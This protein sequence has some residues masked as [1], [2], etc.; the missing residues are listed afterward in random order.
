[1]NLFHRARRVILQ[2]NQRQP[3]LHTPLGSLAFSLTVSG[4]TYLPS[5]YGA[6][7]QGGSFYHY[8]SDTFDCELV[9]CRPALDARLSLALQECWG[10]VF[11]IKPHAPTTI[12]GCS[13]SAFWQEGFSWSES[14]SDTGE[15]L[16]AVVYENPEYRLHLGTQDGHM[17]MIRKHRGDRIPQ[18]LN[19]ESDFEQHG[20]ITSS[21]QGIEVPMTEIEPHETCQI[22]F[23]AAWTR[24]M[25]EDNS[26]WLAVDQPAANILHTEGLL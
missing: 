1:M 17:L 2:P 3:A 26:T 25:E 8:E 9:L 5:H 21:E 10:A 15:H 13:F 16:E 19:L 20:L 18:S 11:R 22:H 12:R 24:N 7:Q 23:V 6:L 14:G 4:Q